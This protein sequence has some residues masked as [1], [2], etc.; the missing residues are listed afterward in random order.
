LPHFLLGSALI[1]FV[2][3]LISTREMATGLPSA[4]GNLLAVGYLG[5]PIAL[6]GVLHPESAVMADGLVAPWD[7]LFVLIGV[8]VS[9]SAAFFTGKWIG[10]HRV[11]P[12]ISPKKSL[13]GYVAGFLAPGFL[14][15][16]AGGLVLPDTEPH[17]L[18]IAGLSIGAAA[19][20][21]DLFESV[22]K[23]GAGIKN[24]SNLIPGHGGILDRIDSLLFALP[25]YYLVSVLFG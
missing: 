7:L 13:E 6:A 15:F 18:L 9:D 22:L 2:W 20:A 24:T 14:A 1:T 17:F 3:C 23:R 12:H 8:W 4:G 16:A 21:G 11:T 25:F 5:I 10:K 19:I